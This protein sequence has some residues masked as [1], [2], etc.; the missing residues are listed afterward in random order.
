MVNTRKRNPKKKAVHDAATKQQPRNEKG[1]IT[2]WSA[3]SEHGGLLKMLIENENITPSMTAGD[4]RKKYSMFADYSYSCFSSALS[5]ARKAFKK[6][7]EC[8]DKQTGKYLTQ[9]RRTVI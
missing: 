4:V 3:T 5:N 6:E 9:R 8:R 7:I 1:E 2:S